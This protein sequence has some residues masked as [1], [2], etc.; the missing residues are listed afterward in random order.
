MGNRETRVSELCGELGVT[1][2][3][4]Y[5]YVGPE[6]ELRES[7]KR[8]LNVRPAKVIDVEHSKSGNHKM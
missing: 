3:T 1:R 2:T 5:R 7:G 4:L 6:R 8:V